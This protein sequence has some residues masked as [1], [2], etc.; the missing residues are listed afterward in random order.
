VSKASY[1]I[2]RYRP[3]LLGRG[4]AKRQTQCSKG[5]ATAIWFRRNAVRGMR[6]LFGSEIFPRY[7]GTSLSRGCGLVCSAVAL[8]CF[9]S[10]LGDG[11]VLKSFHTS[12]GTLLL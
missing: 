6:R 1:S 2:G 12:N 9:A 3:V 10:V 4:G 5:Y 8:G 7:F 11:P